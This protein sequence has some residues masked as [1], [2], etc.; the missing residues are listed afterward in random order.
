MRFVMT[1]LGVALGA[2]AY[3]AEPQT[4]AEGS[5]VCA[6]PEAYD[7]AIASERKRQ[8][9]QALEVELRAKCIRMTSERL[10][11]VMA[12]FVAVVNRSG[13]KARVSFIIEVYERG[14]TGA[15]ARGTPQPRGGLNRQIKYIGWT[16]AANLR[17]Q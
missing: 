9:P 6:T 11:D 12:P 17:A 15:E 16:A 10:A 7:E 4:L 8:D 14:A 2:A 13:D 1:L 5:W 3:G